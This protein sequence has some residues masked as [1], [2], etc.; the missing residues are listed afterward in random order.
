MR[1]LLLI[2]LLLALLINLSA[3]K[4]PPLTTVD[5]VDLTRYT[6]LWHQ[7]AYFPNTFQPKDAKLTTAEYLLGSKGYITVINTAYKD[8]AG[9]EVRSKIVGKAFIADKKTN[10]KLKVQF[11]W[12]FRGAYWITLLDTANYQWAVVSDPSRKYLWI[13]TRKPT[14]DKDLYQNLVQ[15]IAAKGIDINKI[16]VT[17]KFE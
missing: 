2:L 13:L 17:G 8:F 3:R 10:S 11:F 4:L 16:V 12:P 5:R 15:Q 7:F 14:L 6:G 9:K 1:I